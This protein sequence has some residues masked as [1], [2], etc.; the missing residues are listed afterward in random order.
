[1]HDFTA[2]TGF[3]VQVL[4]VIFTPSSSPSSYKSSSPV[5]FIL[6]VNWLGDGDSPVVKLTYFRYFSY[7]LKKMQRLAVKKKKNLLS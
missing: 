6:V 4:Q 1:M 3:E 7:A 2:I 5:V